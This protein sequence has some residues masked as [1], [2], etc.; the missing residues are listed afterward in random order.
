REA[1]SAYLYFVRAEDGIRDHV[2]AELALGMLHRCVG[3]T[4]GNVHAFGEQLEVADQVFH[5]R[6]HAFARWRSDLVVV[7]DDGTRV[8]AQPFNALPNDAI[9]FTHFSDT[10][11]IAVV[12]IAVRADRHVEVETIVDLVRRVLADIPLHARTTQH[13]AGK[14][15]GLGDLGG[16]HTDVHQTLLPDPVVGEQRF[17]FIYASRETIGEIFDEVEQGAGARF[18]HGAHFLLA[19][20]L[21]ATLV[22]G[23]GVRQI[24]V[25]ATRTVIRRVH[26]RAGNSFVAVHEV[27]AFAE[28]IQEDRHGADVQRV[29]TE[30]HQVVQ[31]ACD[32]VEHH[33][34]VLSAQRNLQAQQVF[35]RHDIC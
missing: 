29:R 27:F 19:A 34:D 7:D 13:G 16:H 25:D 11:Q 21:A 14:A 2:D 15:H 17:V 5:A 24:A 12:A 8:V 4:L 20:V 35:H 9:A 26:A 28:G 3:F 33:A 23:H 6:L 1:G 30:G 10:A 32:L 18:V 31:D 22:L